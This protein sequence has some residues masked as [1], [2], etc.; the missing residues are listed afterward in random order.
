[1]FAYKTFYDSDENEHNAEIVKF[2]SHYNVVIDGK[3]YCSSDTVDEALDDIKKAEHIY[4][5]GVGE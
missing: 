1:M 5:F 4:K 2:Q 3:F